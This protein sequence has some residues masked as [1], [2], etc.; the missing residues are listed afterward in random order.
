MSKVKLAFWLIWLPYLIW[1]LLLFNFDNHSIKFKLA[2]LIIGS[3]IALSLLMSVLV[4]I[5]WCED[6]N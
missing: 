3:F 5:C 6:E 4:Y 2:I 1:I